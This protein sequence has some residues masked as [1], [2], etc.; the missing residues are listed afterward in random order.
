M[1][2]EELQ[3]GKLRGRAGRRAWEFEERM[4]EGR[5]S[6]LAQKCWQE[7]RDRMLRGR[8]SSS[9]EREEW[10]GESGREKG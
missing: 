5:G 8:E 7:M 3:R 10:N 2:R 6:I 9:L 1:V 4:A